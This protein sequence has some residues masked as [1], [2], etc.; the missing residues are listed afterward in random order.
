[1]LIAQLT[2]THVMAPARSRRILG[3]TSL[4]LARA[5]AY[6]NAIQPRPAAVLLTGDLT[7]GGRPEEYGR[8]RELLAPLTMPSFVVPGNHD[9]RAALRAAFHD[10]AYLPSH[11][12][13]LHYAVDD[14]PIR[15]VGF[16][17]TR[18][19]FAGGAAAHESRA[20]LA[21]TLDAE[22]QKP[23]LLFLHHP[24]FR[25]GMHYMDAFGFVGLAE[26]GAL[27]ARRAQVRLIVSGHVHRVLVSRCGGV[28]ARTSRSTAR[29]LVPEV[30]ERRPLWIRVEAPSVALHAWDPRAGAFTS[31]QID[32]P[33]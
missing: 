3:D 10:A 29:Q 4:A 8:L 14:F 21:A 13:A 17:S 2:D 22:P 31:R 28:P 25:T 30:L 19:G 23:T 11:G 12:G 26:F 16:D 1:L 20:W 6:L 27:V 5:V 32:V 33:R 7:H 9:R 15:L 24:P 18:P